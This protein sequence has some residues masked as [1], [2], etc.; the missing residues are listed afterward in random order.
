M[1][2]RTS[3]RVL[4][5]VIFGVVAGEFALD[6]V[7]RNGLVDW[8]IYFI[9]VYL[10]SK[11]GGRHFSYLLAGLISLL[12]LVAFYCSPPGIDPRLAL[13]GRGIGM[14]TLWLLAVLIARNKGTE[15][16]LQLTDRALRTISACNQALVHASSES[17]LL[18]DI[19]QQIVDKGGYRMTWVGIP[20][21]NEQ[22][23]VRIAASAGGD[24]G[25]L[26]KAKITWS[27]TSEHGRGPTGIAIRTGQVV[28]VNNFQ[29]DLRTVPWHKEAFK[30]SLGASISLPLKNAGETFGVLMIYAAQTNA[31]NRAEM[32]LLTTLADDLAF[33]LHALRGRAERQV[34]QESLR[35]NTQR[36]EFLLANT[37]A[38]LYSMRATDDFANTFVSANV[39]EVLGH[40]PE[41]F[42]KDT[43]F[44]LSQV[45]PDDAPAAVASF[46]KRPALE[47]MVREYRFRHGDGTY[48][49][50]H[51]E[52]R[53]VPDATGQPQELVGYWF[54]ITERKLAEEALRKREEIFSSIVNQAVDAVVL[55]DAATG[56][57]AE[58]N[59]SAYEGLGYTHEEFAA[60]GIAAIQAEHSAEQIRENIAL[61][62]Q[63]GRHTFE[64]RHRHRDGTLRDVRV[65][66]RPLNLQGHE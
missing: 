22:K 58:F 13:T 66:A 24:S 44:W 63:R 31:F 14:G 43:R 7:I 48:R 12:M 36:L 18:Q 42:L 47:T 59:A 64:N 33:G 51:D 8:V 60:F 54:D 28:V 57:F 35:V 5:L 27:D 9:P 6:M 65:S 55:V 11:V 29:N 32:E 15:N 38:I 4:W 46:H 20:E 21:H 52:T 45:H 49:W 37:P 39:R 30:R 19:C 34:A 62:H 10:S 56:H 40:P 1:S 16:E 2:S 53:A 25:Y 26:A 50:I 41:T 17:V 3:E 23:S 61:I